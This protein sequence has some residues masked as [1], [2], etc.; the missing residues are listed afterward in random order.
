MKLFLL[1]LAFSNPGAIVVLFV[2]DDVKRMIDSLG[3]IN[4]R[5]TVISNL[6]EYSNKT[7]QQMERE[8]IWAKFQMVKSLIMDFCLSLYPD[9]L[10]LDSDIFT[11]N[12]L[13]IPDSC[14]LAL[15]PH[16]IRKSETDLYGYYNGGCVWT[17]NKD[18]PNKWRTYT[19]TSRFYDQ[20][21]LEDCAK[22][23][24]TKEFG[25]NYNI[26][27]WRVSPGES[28][29][30]LKSCITVDNDNIYFNGK[31]IVF[32]HTHFSDKSEFN[33]MIRNLLFMSGAKKD[34]HKIF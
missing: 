23:F 6:N 24:K 22:I 3:D 26:S 34:M 18:M 1:S 16:Y 25:D 4:L 27:W 29:D 19:E 7:R 2:D 10:F 33:I 11:I 15:S 28:I 20:A 21:S 17:N 9:T 31:P 12:E 14:E 30:K 8:R 32:V 13:S 5:L